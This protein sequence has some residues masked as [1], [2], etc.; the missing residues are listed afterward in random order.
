MTTPRPGSSTN[1][2]VLGGGTAGWLAANHMG[3]RF[4]STPGLQGNIILIES[5]TLPTIGV[6]EGTVPAIRNSLHHL[7]ISETDIIQRCDATFKQSIEFIDWKVRKNGQAAHRYH[8]PFDYPDML[9]SNPIPA[10]LSEA[11]PGQ[12]FAEWVGIQSRLIDQGLAPKTFNQAEFQG[13]CHYAYHLDAGKFTALLAEHGVNTFGID[14]I[15]ADISDVVRHPNGNI[16]ALLSDDGRRFEADLYVDCSGFE[17]KLIG[18]SLHVP[19]IDK[20]DILLADHALA[21]QVPYADDNQSIPCAT[22]AHAQSAGWIWDI[23]LYNRRGVGHVYSSNHTSHEQ[24]ERDLRH[25]LR[26]DSGHISLKRIPMRVGYRQSAWQHN[27]VAIGL[28]QGFVEPLEAT[29][30]LMF[31]V[32]ARMLAD[33]LQPNPLHWPLVA[34]RFNQRLL[35]TWE[36]VL[37]FIKLHY[38]L[39]DR[40]DNEF[41]QDNRSPLSQSEWLK[42]NLEYWRYQIPSHYDFSQ[43]GHIFNLENF[44]YVLYG[45]DFFTEVKQPDSHTLLAQKA[46]LDRRYLQAKSELQPHRALLDKIRRHGLQ[47]I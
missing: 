18:Q 44:L 43:Q 20:G 10:Y 39:S 13:V 16:A 21:A 31:D 3:K 34:K 42:D 1:I 7:G 36:R 17:A 25:Y 5:P 14:V 23:G 9:H 40:E 15:Q 33:L 27:V 29:G 8:H 45:M 38:V 11:E 46:R 37:D 24:A 30:L 26:D 47:P 2:I 35:E 41:W 6:G 28:A 4:V 22:L 12:P 19:F 32:S